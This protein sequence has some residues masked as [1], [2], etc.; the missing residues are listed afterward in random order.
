MN[1]NLFQKILDLKH[2][3]KIHHLNQTVNNFD[4]EKLKIGTPI[5]KIVGF[6]NFDNLQINIRQKVF[7]PRFETEE[8]MLEAIKYIK[9]K[10]KVL[11]LCCGSGYIGLSI[12]QKVNCDVTLSDIDEQAIIQT[13]ENKLLNNLN[14]KVIKSNMFEKITGKFDII[15]SN[16]P[17]IPNKTK[18]SPSVLNFEPHHALFGGTDGNDFYRIIVQNA[19]EYLKKNGWLIL[20]ISSD[21]VKFL[22]FHNFKI[23]NDINKKPR[24]AIKQF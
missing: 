20:E 9:K 2:Y 5:Q 23:L 6:I 22:K 14:V 21:N 24:I 3:Q 15:I 7:I 4:I 16:P 11:D 18:L 13:L 17:Y 19:P 8:V 1:F 10:S 12:K